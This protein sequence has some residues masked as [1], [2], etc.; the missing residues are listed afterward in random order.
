MKK[1]VYILLLIIY[2][3]YA[4]GQSKLKGKSKDIAPIEKFTFLVEGENFMAAS[5]IRYDQMDILIGVDFE[6]TKWKEFS[7][8]LDTLLEAWPKLS[9][10]RNDEALHD[11]YVGQCLIGQARFNKFL[12]HMKDIF[13]YKNE[14]VPDEPINICTQEPLG[15]KREEIEREI[16]NLKNRFKHINTMWTPEDIRNSAE[17][18]N[19]LLEFCNYYNEFSTIYEIITNGMV[20]AMGQ[21]SDNKYP[22]ILL[23]DLIKGCNITVNGEGEKY[24]IIKCSKTS[25][26]YRCQIQIAQATNFKEYTMLHAVHYEQIRLMGFA[27]NDGFARTGDVR[28][29]KYLECE[30]KQGGDH[31]ICKENNIPEPCKGMLGKQDV[32]GIVDYCNFTMNI[33]PVAIILP[34]GGILIQGDELIIS[35][36]GNSVSQKP[37]FAMYSPD[38]ITIKYD[39]EDYVYPPAIKVDELMII[40]SKLTIDEIEYLKKTYHWNKVLESMDYESII[41]YTLILL[42]V[43][44]IP[45]AIGSCYF[46]VSQ[47]KLLNKAITQGNKGRGKENFKQNQYLLRKI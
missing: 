30:D 46:A 7:A 6:E 27:E 33:P 44:F 47:R 23:G 2:I 34:H 8:E 45:L 39:E 17:A 28:E 9:F 14:H 43:V 24:S 38:T 15:I 36:G 42:Q 3:C 37:P 12:Q 26:G 22:E 31:S 1:T 32:K 40:E 13:K 4:V 16:I 21:L 10:F 35:N 5:T 18:K 11:E 20:T 29:I 41:D 25:K 19:T